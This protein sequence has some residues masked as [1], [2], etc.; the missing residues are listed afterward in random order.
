M[1]ELAA[2]G[3]ELERETV[4]LVGVT[5]GIEEEADERLEDGTGVKVG[6]CM[7]MIWDENDRV[8]C[9]CWVESP[10]QTKW[11]DLWYRASSTES[12]TRR[13]VPKLGTPCILAPPCTTTSHKKAAALALI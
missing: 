4:E 1:R 7:A 10:F 2:G 13:S 3:K 9:G 8:G 5:V 6:K 12:Q 11:Q